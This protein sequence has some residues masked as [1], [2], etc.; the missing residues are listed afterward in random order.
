ML[1]F[2]GIVLLKLSIKLSKEKTKQWLFGSHTIPKTLTLSVASI[3]EVGENWF[4]VFLKKFCKSG[5]F[6]ISKSGLKS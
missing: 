3:S 2:V 1:P 6:E 4:F 5:I